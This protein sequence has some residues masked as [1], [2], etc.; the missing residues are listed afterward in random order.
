MTIPDSPADPTPSRRTPRQ[1][2]S[3]LGIGLAAGLLSGMFGV[4]GGVIIVP[5]LVLLVGMA[6][7]RA[8]NT[9]LAVIVPVA[10]VGIISYAVNGHLDPTAWVPGLILGAG[11]VIGSLIGAKLLPRVPVPALQLGFAALLV[12][13]I[14][15]LFLVVPSRGEPFP[16]GVWSA[17][18]LI[19]LGL[20]VGI[21]SKLLGVGGGIIIVP[22]LLLIFGVSDLLAR[23]TSL[24]AMVPTAVAGTIDSVRSGK[25]DFV[26]A[27]LLA[28]G[29]IL[30]PPLGAWLAQAVDPF[31]GNVLFAIFLAAIAVQLTVRGLKGLRRS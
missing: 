26:G 4:G 28:C 29:A 17:L 19:V 31:T 22:A 18:G 16:L 3:F 1:I 7:K 2:V 21:L 12:V 24:I 14:V 25:A 27:A 15:S 10:V 5:A 20:A 8:S 6:Q 23:A 9:S 11:G 30:T 13:A